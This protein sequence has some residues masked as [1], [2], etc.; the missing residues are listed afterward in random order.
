MKKLGILVLLTFAVSIVGFAQ[1]AGSAN[2]LARQMSNVSG[3]ALRLARQGITTVSQAEQIQ[4]YLNQI[5][6]LNMRFQNR[7]NRGDTLSDDGIRWIETTNANVN[8][9]QQR[10]SRVNWSNLSD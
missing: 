3:Q 4:K 5:D 10:L 7:I 6:D 9:I 8:E 2:D 1:S